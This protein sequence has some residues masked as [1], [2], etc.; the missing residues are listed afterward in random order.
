MDK[1]VYERIANIGSDDGVKA[2]IEFLEHSITQSR[3]TLEVTDD[4]ERIKM[5]QGSLHAYR[6]IKAILESAD[7][8][9]NMVNMQDT[10][11]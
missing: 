4:I 9:L 3:D 1:K 2:L 7:E 11:S 10:F 6:S 8:I 5:V